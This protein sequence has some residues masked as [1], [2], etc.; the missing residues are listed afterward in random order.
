MPRPEMFKGIAERYLAAGNLTR[1][2]I[3][4][5]A[6]FAAYHAFESIG[7]AW[8]RRKGQKVPKA[9]DSKINKFVALARRETFRHGAAHLAILTTA[10]R[11]KMLYPTEDGAGG[12]NVP[13][14][15]ISSANSRDLLRRVDGMVRSVSAVL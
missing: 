13:D 2:Q 15:L 5:A 8:V 1:D 7:S 3:P 4:E 10:L 11:N 14:K 9:H 6:A 12:F